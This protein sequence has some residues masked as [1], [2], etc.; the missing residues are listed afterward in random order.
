ML[1]CPR[2]SRTQFIDQFGIQKWKNQEIDLESFK[3]FFDI[4]LTDKRFELRGN[5]GDPI[6]YSS[7]I[8]MVQW[9]KEQGATVAITTA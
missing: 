1:K 9:I 8:P 3:Q 2:C 5:D 4:D 6:Y 7:L